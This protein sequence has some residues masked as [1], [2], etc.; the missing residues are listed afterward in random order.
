MQFT[1]LEL[2]LGGLILS[3]LSAL[4]VRLF[5]ARS[6]V[7]REEYSRLEKTISIFLPMVRALI[8]YSKEIPPQDKQDLL[9]GR[10]T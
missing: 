1:P 6:F 4:G 8:V 7:T 2:S 10:N 9:N 5:M 3:F